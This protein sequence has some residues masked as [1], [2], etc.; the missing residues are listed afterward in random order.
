MG[1]HDNFLLCSCNELKFVCDTKFTIESCKLTFCGSVID[2]TTTVNMK[3]YMKEHLFPCL[4]LL[5]Y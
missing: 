4:P 3:F 2:S 1:E 5:L